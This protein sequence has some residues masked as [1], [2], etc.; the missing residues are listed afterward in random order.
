[1]DRPLPYVIGSDEWNACDHIGLKRVD[2]SE[3]L[4]DEEQL[5]S[6]SSSM[7]LDP[8]KVNIILV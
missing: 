3:S 7:S 5:G 1:M 2:S 8:I 4:E 6:D